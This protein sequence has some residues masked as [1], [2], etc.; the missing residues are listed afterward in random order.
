MRS[1][2]AGGGRG[3]HVV[4][5]RGRGYLICLPQLSLSFPL[6]Q[7]DK[8]I[9]EHIVYDFGDTAMMEALRPSIE[10]AFPIQSQVHFSAAESLHAIESLHTVLNQRRM[11][12]APVPPL[13]L[14]P[15]SHVISH[16][17]NPTRPVQDVALDY[18]GK[19]GSTIGA[20]KETRIQYAR[21]L[22]QVTSALSC[23]FQPLGCTAARVA[24][25]PAGQGRMLTYISCFSHAPPATEGVAAAHWHG[26][27]L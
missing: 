6:R 25:H 17:I 11:V 16:L 20:T 15:A 21:E 1:F 14:C 27:V 18:I 4:Q 24:G 19:R 9:L 5:L 23:T 13:L 10:E 8:D 12:V 7:A 22:L 26:R 2:N 3:I